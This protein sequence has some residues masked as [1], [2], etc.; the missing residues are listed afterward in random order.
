MKFFF[1]LVGFFLVAIAMSQSIAE[2]QGTGDVSP[3]AGM[4]VTTT[5]IVTSVGTEGYHIQDG[6]GEYTG[7]YVFDSSYTAELGDEITLTAEVEEFYNLTE[8]KD[9]TAFNV[10]SSNNPLPSPVELTTDEA[11]DEA[12]ESVLIKVSEAECT[13]S[14]LGFGEFELNDGSGPIAVDDFFYL[15]MANQGSKYTITGPLFYSFGAD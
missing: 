13:N 15:F 2:I 11:G 9:V 3:Y 1:T 8:L 12:F 7:I 10:A 5:G 14:N 4:E 6:I